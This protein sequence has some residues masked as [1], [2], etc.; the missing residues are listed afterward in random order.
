LAADASEDR[1]LMGVGKHVQAEIMRG[2]EVAPVLERY[3]T[4]FPIHVRTAYQ[5][6]EATGNLDGELLHACSFLRKELELLRRAA[7]KVTS[8]GFYLLVAAFMAMNIFEM[9]RGP[10]AMIDEIYRDLP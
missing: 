3:P 4:V 7:V 10:M 1:V 6:G 2:R 5:T 8:T 9:Y